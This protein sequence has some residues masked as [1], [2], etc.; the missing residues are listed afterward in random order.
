[1]PNIIICD[2]WHILCTHDNIYIYIICII[3]IT[4]IWNMIKITKLELHYLYD[5]W[6][7]VSSRS[8]NKRKFWVLAY[9]VQLGRTLITHITTFFIKSWVTSATINFRRKNSASLKTQRDSLMLN[10]LMHIHSTSFCV[11]IVSQLHFY[12]R[13]IIETKH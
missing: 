3:Y 1:M 6:K 4:Y 9:C 13:E 7:V 2:T 11:T 10:S 8:I 5:T 12:K